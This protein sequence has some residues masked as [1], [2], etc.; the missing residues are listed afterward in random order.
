MIDVLHP[1]CKENIGH[2][3]EVKLG[4]EFALLWRIVV[5][6]PT[7]L[8]PL[9]AIF[10]NRGHLELFGTVSVSLDPDILHAYL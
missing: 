8:I 6:K 3:K 1:M 5:L 10:R 4:D 9:A 7:D 2:D